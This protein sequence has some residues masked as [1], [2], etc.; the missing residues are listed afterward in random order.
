[1]ITTLGTGRVNRQSTKRKRLLRQW[2]L[3][4]TFA[5]HWRRRPLQPLAQNWLGPE[6]FPFHKSQIVP[7][8]CRCVSP[9]TCGRCFVGRIMLRL[10]ERNIASIGER[11]V[12]LAPP[13]TD[14]P[15]YFRNVTIDSS[16]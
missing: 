4:C 6:R 1:M 7:F 9:V 2:A 3:A 13:D 5:P 11:L 15:E 12:L 8:R 14:L 10:L 16:R